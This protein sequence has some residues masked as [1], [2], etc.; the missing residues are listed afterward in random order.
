MYVCMCVYV[1]QS[2]RRLRRH[3][4][5]VPV[6]VVSVLFTA[7]FMMAG[8]GVVILALLLPAIGTL[9]EM[10]EV[11]THTH[12]RAMGK[13]QGPSRPQA[14]PSPFPRAASSLV[15]SNSVTVCDCVGS[16]SGPVVAAVLGGVC[17]VTPLL[18][19]VAS[20]L[21]P[22]GEHLYKTR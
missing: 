18:V 11:S 13:P 16:S 9:R 6:L 7:N 3:L 17:L 8:M 19:A 5:D 22:R 15:K 1:C 12:T 2:S 21:P 20:R 4:D 10:G 14:L